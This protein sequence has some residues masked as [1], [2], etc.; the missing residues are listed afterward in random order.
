MKA[1]TNLRHK[2]IVS[3]QDYER[4]EPNYPSTTDVRALSLGKAQFDNNEISLK[5]WRHT[6]KKWS[7]QS[8]ELPIH[9]NIDLTILLVGS[10]LKSN[11]LKTSKTS[12]NEEI[13]DIENL[14]YVHKYYN[15]NKKHIDKQ[16]RELKDLLDKF[17]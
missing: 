3:V 13:T 16:L 9:R 10:L 1:P 15:A 2:P 17:L 4:F 7:R 11:N 5:V 8:E 6:T 14:D 12:L